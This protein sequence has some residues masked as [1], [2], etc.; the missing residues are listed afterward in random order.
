M[1][2]KKKTIIAFLCIGII[3]LII[4]TFVT[5]Y[6]MKA[7]LVEQAQDRLS[8]VHDN[9][10]NAI[11][12]YF[13]DIKHQVVSLS[14]DLKIVDATKSFKGVFGKYRSANGITSAEIE[15]M[16]A[17]LLTYYTADFT[18]QYREDNEGA[19]PPNMRSYF[20]MLD[21]DSI[22]FQYSFIKDNPNPLGSKDGLAA[23]REDKSEYSKIHSKIHPPVREFLNAFGYYD[24]FIADSETGDIIYSVDKELD[25]STSLLD[26]P[27]ANTNFGEAFKKA[28]MLTDP[29][30]FVF[31]D[32]KQYWPSYNAP[33]SFIASPIVENGK[34]I[35]VLLF[36]VPLNRVSEVM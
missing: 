5:L 33:A 34:N 25:F 2:M 31:V 22:A 28:R 15:E 29:A 35:G 1:R 7:E 14:N 13:T 11:E 3:P 32:Y 8:A 18:A 23:Y 6:H 10:K 17:A 21:A 24:I 4:S 12:H 16:R 9:R 26:G 27:F 30:A 36:Q 19:E 20:G